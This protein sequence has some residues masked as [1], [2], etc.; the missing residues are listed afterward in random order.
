MSERYFESLL[1]TKIFIP[2]LREDYVSRP[3]LIERLMDAEPNQTILVTAPPGYGKTTLIVDWLDRVEVD[4]AWYS[5]DQRD[6]DLTQFLTYIIYSL[7]EVESGVCHRVLERFHS[8]DPPPTQRLLNYFI[9]DLSCLEQRV[10][11]VIDDYHLIENGEIHDALSYLLHNHPP[12]IQ[13]VL[14]SRQKLPFSISTLRAHNG[15]LELGFFDLRFTIEEANAFLRQA[16][17]IELPLEKVE[18]LDNQVEGWVTGLQLAALSMRHGGSAEDLLDHFSGEDRVVQKY[19]FEEVFSK[20]P[21]HIQDFLIQTS[22]LNRF[23]APLCNAVLGIENSQQIIERLEASNLF[24]IPLDNK[25]EWYRYHHLFAESLQNRLKNTQPDL[26]PEL[27]RKASQWHRQHGEIEEAVEY[28]IRADDFNQASELITNIVNRVIKQGG[29]RKILRWL[30]A[31]PPQILRSNYLLWFHFITAHLGLGKF[32]QARASLEMLWGDMPFDG[33]DLDY[34][35]RMIQ[36]YHAGLLSSIEI[37]TTMDAERVQEL[38]KRAMEVLPEDVDFGQGIGPGYY[39]VASYHLGDIAGAKT[40][41]ERAIRL[42]KKH[43]YSR[44]GLLWTSYRAQIV[45][46]SGNLIK[47]EKYLNQA[48]DIAS[49]IGVQESNVVSNVILGFGRLAYE[50]NRLGEAEKH[51]ENGIQIAKDGNF[52]DHLVWGY[53]GYFRYLAALGRF[54]EARREISEARE[55]S[56]KHGRSSIILEHLDALETFI[57]LQ[58]G[59]GI[60]AQAWAQEVGHWAEEERLGYKE[61][62]WLTLARA[63]LDRDQPHKA[64]PLLQAINKEAREHKRG[65]GLVEGRILLSKAYALNRNRSDAKRVLVEALKFTQPHGY[66]RSYLDQGSEIWSLL[67]DV[68]LDEGK[69]HRMSSSIDIERLQHLISEFE[70]EEDRL[71]RAGIDTELPSN[72]DLLTKREGEIVTLLAEGLSYAEIASKLTITENTVKTHIKNIYRKLQVNNRTEAVNKARSLNIL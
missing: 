44:L 67:Q 59:K 56:I 42:S 60:K 41:I 15:L 20:Q 52:L 18:A 55:I 27:Y 11:L 36:A 21:T 43:D 45:L 71:R 31:F 66:I 2:P 47:A 16:F 24:I 61:F 14:L 68:S 64:V 3:R 65:M 28:A 4:H 13:I 37:H 25:K 39:A 63:Y 32:K 6:N 33:E 5:I 58:E 12:Q 48:L 54:D 8:P 22:I 40:H 34:S 72:G 35:Q 57:D 62:Q 30:S 10:I 19:L 69:I 23:S 9:N 49:S 53:Q 70:R 1:Q 50:K 26:P 29:R 17:D 51:L 7:E 46:A 38:A